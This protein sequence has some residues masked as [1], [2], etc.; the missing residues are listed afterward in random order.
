MNLVNPSLILPDQNVF[1]MRSKDY[2]HIMTDIKKMLEVPI[3]CGF[4][5]VQFERKNVRYSGYNL[6]NTIKE[7]IIVKLAK[8]D[9]VIDLSMQVP[10]LIDNQWIV[11]NGRRKI[12]RYQLFDIPILTFPNNNEIRIN[13]NLGRISVT[14]KNKTRKMDSH[15]NIS[16]FSKKISLA[17]LLCAFYGPKYIAKR[18]LT[19]KIIDSLDSIKSESL[20]LLITDL[21]D[22]C[23]VDTSQQIY[24]ELVGEYFTKRNTII[25]GND[26][27]FS[28]KHLLKIDIITKRFIK[29][30]NVLECLLNI[31]ENNIVYD[32]VNYEN[33]RIRCFEYMIVQYFI[34]NIYKLCIT[35]RNTAKPK[36]NVSKTKILGDCNVSDIVQYDFCINPID[37]L[38]QLTQ[39]TLTGPNGFKKEAIPTKLKDLHPTMFGKICPV[40]TPDRENCGVVQNLLPTV[41]IDKNFKF[42]KNSKNNSITSIAVSMVPFAEYTDQT[43]LQMAAGQMKQSIMLHDFHV[44]YICSGAESQ[45]TKFSDFVVTAEEDGKILHVDRK[46]LIIGYN[47][48]KVKVFN[49]GVKTIVSG[50]MSFV[51]CKYKTGYVFQKDSVIAYSTFCKDNIITIGQNFKIAFMSYYGYNN[52]DGIVISDRL[53]KDNSLSSFHYLDM[54]IN[55]SPT[56]VLLDLFDGEND[57]YTP[58]HP[59]GTSL[60]KG[61]IYA[62]IKEMYL[63]GSVKNDS[64][65]VFEESNDKI[66]NYDL[67]IENITVYANEWYRELKEYDRWIE[68]KIQSQIDDNQRLIDVVKD[69]CDADEAEILIAENRLDYLSHPGKYK[70]KDEVLKGVNIKINGV[71][72]RPIEVGDKLA[73]RHGNKGIIT[74]IVKHEKMPQLPDGTH[75]DI[76]LNPM[77]VFSR[78]NL[79]QLFEVNLAQSLVDLQK[80]MK[81]MLKNNK[82]HD[83]IKKYMMDYVDMTDKTDEKWVSQ[84]IES[85]IP[86]DIT[87]EYIESIFLIQ[88][89]YHTV[90]LDDI[91]KLMEYTNSE[92]EVKLFDPVFGNHIKNEI[93]VGYMYM[94]K[95]AHIAENKLTVRSIGITS[96]KT[97]QP[98]SG[99]K[100]NGGQ[101][102]GEMESG[103]LIALDTPDNHLELYTVKS[104]CIDAKNNYLK[105]EIG[106]DYLDIEVNPDMEP[107]TLKLLKSNLRIIDIDIEGEI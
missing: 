31:I 32:D 22:C 71:Y 80:E 43:R 3:S 67:V 1:N 87:E 13:T 66:A 55:V 51:V 65:T 33:K 84:Y 68:S 83:D 28:I 41:E 9:H 92:Y 95:L 76:C 81:L 23:D 29:E 48:G 82:S 49:I 37:Q 78:M 56:K 101:R 52:E 40:D 14:W 19:E 35:N 47:S 21:I 27:I 58:L 98:V 102:C 94:M 38:S 63:F 64:Y 74:S 77:G 36:F 53:Q 70:T 59:I 34:N 105:K 42:K 15:V 72:S 90:K 39:I 2:S 106:T 50:N 79:G 45:F 96:K 85:K 12:P 10:K 69:N 107:E 26:Y 97:M 61:D 103:V 6:I 73:N 46:H 91:E 88:P 100:N 5:L 30:D 8:G 25:K 75:V 24:V 7:N 4:E 18:Y 93:A 99:K 44:P 57:K 104:D 11:I 60:K 86:D 89:Q 17:V 54:S 20:R 16:V 62:K